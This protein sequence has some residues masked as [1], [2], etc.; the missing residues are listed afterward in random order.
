MA[1]PDEA[2]T[3]VGADEPG[4][5]GDENAL[6]PGVG[7]IGVHVNLRGECSNVLT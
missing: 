2:L 1:V 6:G 4:T 5:S 7:M 3:E